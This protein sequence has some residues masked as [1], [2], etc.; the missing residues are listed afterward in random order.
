MLDG[1]L[2]EGQR[3]IALALCLKRHS[4]ILEGISY[5][6]GKLARFRLLLKHR[7]L[8]GGVGLSLVRFTQAE[9]KRGLSAQEGRQELRSLFAVPCGGLQDV[10]CLLGEPARGRKVTCCEC[11]ELPL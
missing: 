1:P 8:F 11:C 9:F 4:K 10:H 7:K 2:K 6:G 5:A 3:L